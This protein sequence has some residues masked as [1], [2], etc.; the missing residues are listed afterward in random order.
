MLSRC[1]RAPRM[2]LSR[3]G[4]YSPS[5]LAGTWQGPF[6]LAGRGAVRW[7]AARASAP[8]IQNVSTWPARA[9]QSGRASPTPGTTRR[10]QTLVNPHPVVVR[11]QVLVRDHLQARVGRLL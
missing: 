9:G 4:L 2:A 5:S 1:S 8:R 6:L 11:A 10:Q 7:P 3:G